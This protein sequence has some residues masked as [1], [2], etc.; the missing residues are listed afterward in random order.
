MNRLKNQQKEITRIINKVVVFR[1]DATG[2][3]I[4]MLDLEV[5]LT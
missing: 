3:K 1:E 2:D 5:E 4:R